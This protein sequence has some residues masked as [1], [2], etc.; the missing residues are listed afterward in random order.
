MAQDALS[1]ERWTAGADYLAALRQLGLEPEGLLWAFHEARREMALVL[2][3]SLVERIGPKDLYEVLFEAYEKAG[4]PRSI[5]P[6]IV[7]AFGPDSLLGEEF[8]VMMEAEVRV[9]EAPPSLE[10]PIFK[11]GLGGG[12]YTFSHEWVYVAKPRWRSE[13]KHQVKIWNTFREN[14]ARLA[15]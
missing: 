12:E 3:T 11:Y 14:V 5:D 2:V 4:T 9:V 10:L 8:A 6:W 7:V 13:S 1:E 15:A